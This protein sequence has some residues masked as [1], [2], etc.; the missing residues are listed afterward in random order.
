MSSIKKLVDQVKAAVETVNRCSEELAK[1]H[2]VYIY[3][4]PLAQESK[5]GDRI[6]FFDAIMH[7]SVIEKNHDSQQEN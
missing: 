2:S 3:L 4:R 7:K 6:E 5:Q 1:D